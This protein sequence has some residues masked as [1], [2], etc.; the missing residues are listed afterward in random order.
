[1]KTNQIYIKAIFHTCTH[2]HSD[3]YSQMDCYREDLQ[4]EDG[5]LSGVTTD[6]EDSSSDDNRLASG[7]EDDDDVATADDGLD[8]GVSVYEDDP[9]MNNEIP[10]D[11]PTYGDDVQMDYGMFS[12][13]VQENYIDIRGIPR[14]FGEIYTAAISCGTAEEMYQLL[15]YPGFDMNLQSKEH[16]SILQSVARGHMAEGVFILLAAGANPN[17][18]NIANMNSVLHDTIWNMRHDCHFDKNCA[19]EG[20]AV[21]QLL[22]Y[23][24]ANIHAV[25]CFGETPLH[26]AAFAGHSNVVEFLL[27]QG[28]YTDASKYDNESQTPHDIARLNLD[29]FHQNPRMSDDSFNDIR[30]QYSKVES[31]LSTA[32]AWCKQC[33]NMHPTDMAVSMLKPSRLLQTPRQIF[34]FL[35]QNDLLVPYEEKWTYAGQVDVGGSLLMKTIQD[36]EIRLN[37]V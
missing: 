18:V 34:Q 28:A 26:I 25:N 10:N 19:I 17:T 22:V 2:I 24:G 37:V 4:I 7:D 15:A 16:C 33:D 8:H 21:I 3:K 35:S 6:E 36:E 5:M 9:E 20:M 1:V 12:H 13:P 31:M 30:M 11:L 29:R 32:Q 23:Y 14:G 27:D